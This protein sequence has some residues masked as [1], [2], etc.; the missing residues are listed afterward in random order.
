LSAVQER[1]ETFPKNLPNILWG[2]HHEWLRAHPE[3]REDEPDFGCRLN[4]PQREVCFAGVLPVWRINTET[5]D[6]EQCVFR[7][8]DC[9]RHHAKG[10]PEGYLEELLKHGWQVETPVFNKSFGREFKR[11]G[12]RG[13]GSAVGDVV[14]IATKMVAQGGV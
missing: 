3:L 4:T 10:W 13:S 12:N 2:L 7:C 11:G 14:Q 9:G 5:K 8:M 6:W 1:C